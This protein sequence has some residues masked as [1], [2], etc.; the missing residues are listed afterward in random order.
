ME[1]LLAFHPPG[2]TRKRAG[3]GFYFGLGADAR[4][5]ASGGEMVGSSPLWT[6]NK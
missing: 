3:A 4:P 2:L 6:E 5:W 1:A